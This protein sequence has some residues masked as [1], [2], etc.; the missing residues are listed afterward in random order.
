MATMDAPSAERNKEP[1]W[2]TLCEFIFEP[3]IDFKMNQSTKSQ[4]HPSIR[5]LEA[6]AGAGVHTT[7]FCQNLDQRLQAIFNPYFTQYLD[8]TRIVRFEWIPTDPDE[9]CRQSIHQRCMSIKPLLRHGT[10]HTPLSLTLHERGVQ[11][12]YST[13]QDIVSSSSPIDCILCINMIHIAPWQA[14][15]GLMKMAYK[16]H[17]FAGGNDLF[18]CLYGPFLRNGT[19]VESNL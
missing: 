15:I 5:I 18:L 16:I 6:A 1:I 13:H 10:I 17:A 3:L 2:E 8:D 19:A 4:H 7:Y 12:E 9:N 11:E 14:T